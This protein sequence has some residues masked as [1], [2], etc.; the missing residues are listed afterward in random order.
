MPSERLLVGIVGVAFALLV[1]S[2]LIR[3][4]MLAFHSVTQVL[5]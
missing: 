5:S 3:V 2:Q 1:A 4:I